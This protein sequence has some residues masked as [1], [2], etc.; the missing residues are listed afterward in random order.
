MGKFGVDNPAPY[1]FPNGSMLMLGRDDYDSVGWIRADSVEGPYLLQTIIGPAP[2]TVEDPFLYADKRGNF[3]ALFHGGPQGGTY[4]AVGA[5]AF[6]KD[7][8]TWSF[9]KNAAYTT[10]ITLADGSEHTFSR[11]ERPH[12]LMDDTGTITHLYTSLWIGPHDKTATF[13]QAV[14]TA[15]A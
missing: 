5:H 10:T 13:A 15:G 1:F 3:H 2:Y 4:K 8:I 12:L 7:G 14:G 6:S 9:S 11:R